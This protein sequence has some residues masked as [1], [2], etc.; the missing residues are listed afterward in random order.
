MCSQSAPLQYRTRL[1]IRGCCLWRA[2]ITYEYTNRH[3]RRAQREHTHSHATSTL[4]TVV[5][6]AS[7]AAIAAAPSAPMRF[8]A[9]HHHHQRS[10]QIGGIGIISPK[11]L[12]YHT[13]ARA[14]RVQPQRVRNHHRRRCGFLHAA[15]AHRQE[16][17][18]IIPQF[19]APQVF[20]IF[21]TQARGTQARTRRQATFHARGMR[22][23]TD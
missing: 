8:S 14:R 21:R 20:A 19:I 6:C 23:K 11:P 15:A 7:A 5:F 16:G 13:N 9:V 18:Q 1:L 22:R 4:V 2:R 3:A 12:T 10:T 17:K